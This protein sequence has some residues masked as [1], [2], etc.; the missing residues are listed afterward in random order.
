MWVVG[1]IHDKVRGRLSKGLLEIRAVC[2]RL[3][4]ISKFLFGVY[5][6]EGCLVLLPVIE[7]EL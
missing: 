6:I 1:K 5:I 2:V 4:M 7:L 3:V